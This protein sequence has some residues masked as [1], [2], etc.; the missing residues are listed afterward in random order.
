MTTAAWDREK[1]LAEH[2]ELLKRAATTEEG[3]MI[4]TKNHLNSPILRL[5]GEIRNQIYRYVCETTTIRYGENYEKRPEGTGTACRFTQTF[6]LTCKQWHSEAIT[7]M[8]G[9]ATFEVSSTEAWLSR[10]SFNPKYCSLITSLSVDSVVIST[11]LRTTQGYTYEEDE[12]TLQNQVDSPL[13]RLPGEIRNKIY[14]YACSRTQAVFNNSPR[15]RKSTAII[16]TCSQ[17]RH[18]AHAIFFAHATL[19]LGALLFSEFPQTL[20]HADFQLVTSIHLRSQRITRLL[21]EDEHLVAERQGA[22]LFP[23]LERVYVAG[24]SKS[25]MPKDSLGVDALRTWA[26]NADL[27]VAPSSAF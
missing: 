26:G 9:L 15:A 4:A 23:E 8:Y 14:A 3:D 18:E 27:Q 1:A 7:L 20:P 22:K 13:L 24:W 6:L 2:D 21:R 12:D 11:A 16:S 19:D 5:P 25:R 10:Q 17:M